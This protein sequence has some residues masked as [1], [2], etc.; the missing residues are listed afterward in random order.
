MK[1]NNVL[2]IV[3]IGVTDKVGSTSTNWDLAF[4]FYADGTV[5]IRTLDEAKEIAKENNLNIRKDNGE[6]L[7]NNYKKY[8]TVPYFNPYAIIPVEENG[9]KQEKETKQV[10]NKEQEETKQ[11]EKQ[12]KRTKRK[13]KQVN[14]TNKQKE[15][16]DYS[17]G[18]DGNV[19]V[20]GVKKAATFLVFP[21]VFGYGS[22]VKFCDWAD[23]HILSHVNKFLSKRKQKK[24]LKKEHQK[25]IREKVKQAFSF[26]DE[27]YKE[28]GLWRGS[29][30]KANQASAAATMK[31]DKTV[32]N[33]TE[34]KT[35]ATLDGSNKENQESTGT[36][37]PDSVKQFIN[38]INNL[39]VPQ[40][41]KEEIADSIV[42]SLEAENTSTNPKTYH[43]K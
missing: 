11:E 3:Q 39:N 5:G 13:D 31:F 22:I 26:D 28:E 33:D 4:V 19:F 35:A 42:R 34:N 9:K 29:W 38:K 27:S 40:E 24:K 21:F 2:N 16:D 1:R 20:R 37:I 8:R 12:K 43:K 30:G 25:N 32:H 17:T 14:K 10:E 36:V 23:E 41:Q 7:T 15:S 18:K 6:S